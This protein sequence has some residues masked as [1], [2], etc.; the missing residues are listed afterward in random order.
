MS[1]T[2]EVTI[3]SV[4]DPIREFGEKGASVKFKAGGAVLEVGTNR[5]Y[6]PQVQVLLR[7][8]VGQTLPI[9]A[10][11]TE[12]GLKV[13]KSFRFPGDPRKP[14]GDGDYKKKNRGGDW[15]TASERE[16]KEASITAQ[17]AAKIVAEYAETLPI[18]GSFE[19]RTTSV[20]LAIR[21]AAKSLVAE[22]GYPK[23]VGAGESPAP[24]SGLPAQLQQSQGDAQ[25]TVGAPNDADPAPTTSRIDEVIEL[26]GDTKGV[27]Q[28]KKLLRASYGHDDFSKLSDEEWARFLIE[29]SG[30]GAPA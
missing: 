15:E 23:S 22:G 20:A 14:P 7:T 8:L 6:A 25:A 17:V 16:F 21:H 9:T 30:L 2:R 24:G 5:E 1:E 19:D 3:E 27:I 10:E 29:L 18:T 11:K 12:Y 4:M 26:I 13:D 28:A